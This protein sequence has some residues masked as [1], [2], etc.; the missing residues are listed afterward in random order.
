MRRIAKARPDF[1]AG[2]GVSVWRAVRHRVPA[3]IPGLG[4]RLHIRRGAPPPGQWKRRLRAVPPEASRFVGP[5]GIGRAPAF[6]ARK[7]RP[8]SG[9]RVA[10]LAAVESGLPGASGRASGR[11]TLGLAAGQTRDGRASESLPLQERR[12]AFGWAE[13]AA[14]VCLRGASAPGRPGPAP[15]EARPFFRAVRYSP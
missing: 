1:R 4:K 11:G 14:P 2:R 15:V 9:G 13:G 8:P 10:R 5:A 12:P 6:R 7:G 3:A